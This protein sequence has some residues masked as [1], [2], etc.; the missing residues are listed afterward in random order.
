MSTESRSRPSPAHVTRTHT[1]EVALPLAEAMALF[2]PLGETWWLPGWQPTF[3]HPASGETREGGVFTTKAPDDPGSTLW[4]V[5]LWQ[6]QQGRAR[7]ARV[8]PGS[9]SALVDVAARPIGPRTTAV[10]VSYTVTALADHGDAWL[11]RFTPEAFRD[12]LEKWAG[13]IREYLKARHDGS[14]TTEDTKDTEDKSHPSSVV[15]APSVSSASSVVESS[16]AIDAHEPWIRQCYALAAEAVDRGNHPFGALLVLDGRVVATARNAV[17]ERRDATAHAEME[18]LR[19]IAGTLPPEA[20]ARAV[21]YTSTE[22]CAMCASAMYWTGVSTVV[23]GCSTDA[24][25]AAAGGEFLVP[26]RAVFAFGRRPVTVVGPILEEEGAS[27]HW[28]YWASLS[29]RQD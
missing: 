8:T 25:A 2:T 29:G 5:A 23:F 20:L 27:R 1:I 4:T 17:G 24:L 14:F 26:C 18:L 7:Y 28:S 11:A 19:A 22:P 21:L 16:A 13:L 15:D 6:P 12:D 3:I 9:R 10:T